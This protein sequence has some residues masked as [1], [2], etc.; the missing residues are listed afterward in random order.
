MRRFF[1]DSND[2]SAPVPAIRG[3]DARHIKNVLRLRPGDRILLIDGTGFEHEA[4]IERFEAG[5]V[6][7]SIHRRVP[8]AAESPLQI[9]LAQA[10]IKDKKMDRLVR[11]LTEL[12]I[13]RWVPFSAERSVPRPDEKRIS[14]RIIRWEKIAREAVKQ[15]RRGRTPEIGPLLSF[16]ETL[17]LARG[18]DRKIAFWEAEAR[19]PDRTGINPAP[20]ISSLFVLIGPEGGFS[21][22]E[23]AAARSCGFLTLSLGP[24]I[25]RAETATVAAVALVQYLF[26]D[27]GQNSL[28]KTGG[29]E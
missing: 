11:Q 24:R 21:T 22:R 7:V 6:M 10:L 13:S 1:I 29:I 12:G 9:T 23:M 26:G 25:L 16:D 27:M 28:D 8:A 17:D 5:V 19:G 18:Y 3:A 15:C 2:L 4:R 14:A 20:G